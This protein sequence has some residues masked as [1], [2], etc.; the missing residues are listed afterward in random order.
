M[1]QTRPEYETI[2]AMNP[3]TLVHGIRSMKRLKRVI[4]NR[5]IIEETDPM[6]L[7]TGIH[8]LTLEPAE[9]QRQ[10]VV[11]PD[12]HLDPENTSGTG[13]NIKPS[14]SKATKYV[15]QKVAEF[16]TANAGKKFLS[17]AQYQAALNAIKAINERPHLKA[18]IDRCQ[19][20]I[21]LRGEILGLKCKGRTDLI[22]PYVNDRFGEI[23][24]LKT[25]NDV[26]PFAFGRTVANQNY[27]FKM[28]FYRELAQQQYKRPFV[29]GIIAQETKGDFDNTYYP[30][31]DV[32]LDNAFKQVKEV[33]HQYQTAME[34]NVWT[35]CDGG[36]LMSNLYIPSWN[37]SDDDGLDWGQD[38]MASEE[39]A[40]F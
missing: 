30:I 7:G 37:M 14:E 25:T 16:A 32:A 13:K 6:R 26:E 2:Y 24:D 20:E 27:I 22:D 31:P 28:A 17:G 23:L 5:G 10:F 29:C 18:M 9:F 38:S 1:N 33:I 8:A 35:G 4:D 34:T 12:F 15:K 36:A 3:S 40:Y 21:T 39:Q 19:K 11:V